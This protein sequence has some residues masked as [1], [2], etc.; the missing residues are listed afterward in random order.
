MTES[1]VS[2]K[3]FRERRDGKPRFEEAVT[4]F[5][6][7]IRNG[8]A[9]SPVLG[10]FLWETAVCPPPVKSSTPHFLSARA[11]KRSAIFVRVK[12]LRKTADPFFFLVLCLLSGPSPGFRRI[13]L[14]R[15]PATQRSARI[16]GVL[17]PAAGALAAGASAA[18]TTAA[19]AATAATAA[20]AAITAA[21]RPSLPPVPD[22]PRHDRRHDRHKDQA[23]Q[24][25]S[26]ICRQK[27]QHPYRLPSGFTSQR[28][29]PLAF[30]R[31]LSR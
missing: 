2:G 9:P 19:A 6:F 22:H 21:G 28:T 17:A 11:K 14:L 18:A 24:N 25:R 27:P 13:L 4:A 7:P 31:V 10:A 20:A 12:T 8:P 23:H 5:P 15:I 29:A 3:P 30:S 26:P 1:P 16:A